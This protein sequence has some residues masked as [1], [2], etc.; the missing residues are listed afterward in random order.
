MAGIMGIANRASYV[1]SKHAVVGLTREMTMEVGHLG[2]R[3]NA[4]APGI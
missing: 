2:I 3:V 4:V 1:S